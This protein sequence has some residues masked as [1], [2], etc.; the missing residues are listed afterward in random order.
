MSTL[1][2]L[3]PVLVL[4]ASPAFAGWSMT[5]V[6]TTSGTGDGASSAPTTQRVWMEG[7]AAKI[8]MMGDHPMMPSGS[9]LLVQEG[10]SKMF[11][12]NPASRTYA[13]FDPTAMGAGMEA[14]QGSGVE[15]TIEEPKMVKLVEEPGPEMLGRPTTHYRYRTTYTAVM[16]MPM[17][18]KTSTAT[19]MV[20]DLWTTPAIAAGGAGQ[21]FAAVTGGGEVHQQLRELA[22]EVKATLVGLP[23]K[24]VTVTKTTTTSQ[25]S[26]AMGMLMRRAGAGGGGEGSSTTTMV[27]QDLVEAPLPAATFQL[28]AGYSE[29]EMMQRGP[30]MPDLG[31]GGGR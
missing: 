21:A 22:R 18:M 3:A 8:E 2:K 14:M 9:Y 7:A 24:Q 6:T 20:E 16:S 5:Q 30:A 10:G 15:L 31:E 27:V 1:S 25:G 19:D 29:A 13:R 17:G 26:G 28:P 23:L 4:V 11:M 12:V